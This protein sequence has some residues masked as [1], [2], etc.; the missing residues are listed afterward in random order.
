MHPKHF[1]PLQLSTNGTV[2]TTTR[3]E[4]DVTIYGIM[5]TLSDYRLSFDFHFRS[6][7][8]GAVVTTTRVDVTICGMLFT[9]S[10]YRIAF[11]FFA[12]SMV[13]VFISA[14]QFKFSVS[15]FF[16]RQLYYFICYV[17]TFIYFLCPLIE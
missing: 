14:L 10:D 15:F 2:I 4:I 13:L 6:L 8:T 7:A 3:V 5:F 16:N 11:Y 9:L 12:G 17:I 1:S